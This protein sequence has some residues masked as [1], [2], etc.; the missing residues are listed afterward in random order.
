[1]R[2]VGRVFHE[3]YASTNSPCRGSAVR[4]VDRSDL[5]WLPQPRPL[6]R[7]PS[8][9][10]SVWPLGDR[11]GRGFGSDDVDSAKGPKEVSMPASEASM[12]VRPTRL[13]QWT[14]R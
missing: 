3:T 5:A 14:R 13:M 7:L 12:Q 4:L 10:P 9:G 1:M 11:V 8:N 2:D 6:L